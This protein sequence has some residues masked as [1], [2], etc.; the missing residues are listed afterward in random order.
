VANSIENPDV[1]LGYIVYERGFIIH[2]IYVKLAFRRFGIAK[3]LFLKAEIPNNFKFT[4]RTNDCSWLI[5]YMKREPKEKDMEKR[6]RVW[7][8][9]LFPSAVYDP[10]EVF[11]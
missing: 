2:Y 6:H 4:H 8:K 10:Y 11:I 9:G 5:G 1:T 7:H 3:E